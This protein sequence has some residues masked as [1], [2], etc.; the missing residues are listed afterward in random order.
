[1][2]QVS[3][4]LRCQFIWLFLT[5]GMLTGSAFAGN[6]DGGIHVGVSCNR[7]DGSQHGNSFPA[8]VADGKFTERR[9][10][11]RGDGECRAKACWTTWEGTIGDDGSF[12]MV[13]RENDWT[14]SSSY[15]S[16]WVLS[17]KFATPDSGTAKVVK[18][19]RDWLAKCDL[20]VIT[21]EDAAS[22]S[23]AARSIAKQAEQPDQPEKAESAV[24]KDFRSVLSDAK[25]LLRRVEAYAKSS[26]DIPR[27]IDIAQAASRLKSAI[28]AS[29]ARSSNQGLGEQVEKLNVDLTRMLAQD[30]GYADFA[31]AWDEAKRQSDAQSA[32]KLKDKVATLHGFLVRYVTQNVT[33]DANENLFPHIRALEELG[34]DPGF[35]QLETVV[36]AAEAAIKSAGLASEYGGVAPSDVDTAE[37]AAESRQA[38]LPGAADPATHPQKRV[39]LVIGNSAYRNAVELLNPRNDA[40]AI[41]AMLLDLGF[42]VVDGQDLDKNAMERAIREFIRKL[43]G[44]DVSFFFYAGH[45]MQVAG[46]NYLIPVDA[47]LEDAAA[48]DFETIDADR[49]LGYM[50]EENRIAIALLDACRD[51]PLS[52]KFA[53]VVGAS[54]SAIVGRGLAVPSTIGGGI[55]IGFATAPGEVALDGQSSNSPF[56]AALLKYMPQKG[57]EIQQL[58]TKVKAEVYQSTNKA[59]SPWHNSD[60]RQEFYLRP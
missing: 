59:Q 51:N 50:A 20:A 41:T 28:K 44:A 42:E 48:V 32:I 7:Y 27:I 13:I 46:K 29:E 11:K 34:P 1:M 60:L 56:T 53:R 3:A 40:R 57:L 19:P 35:D 6:Y 37:T 43:E 17:G 49:V 25:L 36:A 31:R 52:R 9:D 26:N 21:L 5:V 38:A 45:G 39:A 12:N 22:N 4:G 47:S 18:F 23:L 8:D 54:R 10:L 2:I 58:M 30:A 33:S 16:R 55:L 14:Q 24:Q 15:V